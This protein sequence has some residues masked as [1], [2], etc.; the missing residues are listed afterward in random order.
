MKTPKQIICNGLIVNP[1]PYGKDD[2][3]YAEVV[4]SGYGS[5]WRRFLP[6]VGNWWFEVHLASGA[7]LAYTKGGSGGGYTLSGCIRKAM[8]AIDKFEYG[9]DDDEKTI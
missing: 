6:W 9:D 1:V 5:W 8:E 3:I 4:P 7:T 2:L